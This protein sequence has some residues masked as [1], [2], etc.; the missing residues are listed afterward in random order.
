MVSLEHFALIISFSVFACSF[1]Y[2]LSL[3]TIQ[4][5]LQN[6]LSFKQFL[7]PVLGPPRGWEQAVSHL[8]RLPWRVGGVLG[9]SQLVES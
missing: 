4:G 7:F 3:H 5:Q 6:R 9:S 8:Y 1:T 2:L